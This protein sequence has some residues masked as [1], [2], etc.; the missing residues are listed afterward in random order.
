M[1]EV[2]SAVPYAKRFEKTLY[3]E[4]WLRKQYID[5]QR[6]APDIGRELGCDT[7]AVTGRLKRFGIP[8]RTS[9]EA[10]AALRNK[11]WLPRGSSAP[12]PRSEFKETL[13]NPD[14]L[15][16]KYLE[17]ELSS[18]QIARELGCSHVSVFWALKKHGLAAR[19]V[20]RSMIGR[21][22]LKRRRAIDDLTPVALRARARK[23]MP[24]GPC[25]VC[26]A[27]GI[28]VNHKDRDIKN[29]DAS[30]LER[31]CRKCHGAQH[32][33]EDKIAIEWLRERLGVTYIDLHIAARKRLLE[34]QNGI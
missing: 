14:W 10:Y 11:G 17:E 4:N 8:L 3:N 23:Q 31:L 27:Y 18:T 24:P 5:E 29:H 15:R 2:Q 33:I 20:S 6:S 16:R 7:S 12:R 26:G 19:D 1:L 28:D 22:N 34:K 30:N 21:S 32:N 9:Q 13:H 25:I